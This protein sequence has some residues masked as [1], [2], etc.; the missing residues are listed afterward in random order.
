[1]QTQRHALFPSEPLI[2]R[3]RPK[4]AKA[5][6]FYRELA[7][8]QTKPLS[9]RYLLPVRCTDTTIRNLPSAT[10]AARCHYRWRR[11][12]ASEPEP[13]QSGSHIPVPARRAV[14]LSPPRS[15][16][17]EDD[18]HRAAELGTDSR[19]RLKPT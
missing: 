10:P 18:R 12:S 7:A 1:S 2:P 8:V 4:P 9:V 16:R 14:A 11:P 17:T 3:V 19:D 6:A 5:P 15:R 13:R